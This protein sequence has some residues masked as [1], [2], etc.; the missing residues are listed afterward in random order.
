MGSGYGRAARIRAAEG[1]VMGLLAGLSPWGL[2]AALVLLALNE[3]V[4]AAGVVGV[5][6]VTG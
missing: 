1:H 4:L 2:A 5:D 6:L 3:P